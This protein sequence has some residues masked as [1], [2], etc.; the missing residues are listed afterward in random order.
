V[1]V[2]SYIV[3][4]VIS[5][6]SAVNYLTVTNPTHNNYSFDYYYEYSNTNKTL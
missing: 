4:F 5:G 3:D 1:V 6:G 2:P